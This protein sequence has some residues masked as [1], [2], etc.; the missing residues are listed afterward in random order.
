MTSQV[1]KERLD[2]LLDDALKGQ[3]GAPIPYMI[4]ALEVAKTKCLTIQLQIEAI[5]MNKAMASKIVPASGK[6]PPIN[7][8]R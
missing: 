8:P 1:F 2:E 7:P 4:F 3:T 5:Q 6:L